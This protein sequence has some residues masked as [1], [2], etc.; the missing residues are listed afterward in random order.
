MTVVAGLLV[1][2][3]VA[4]VWFFLDYIKGQNA[5]H[6]ARVSE[7][8]TRIQHPEIVRPELLDRRVEVAPTEP[9]DE[10]HLI[11]TISGGSTMNGDNADT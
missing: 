11:G 5:E 7:L 4:T 6:E 1:V 3:I 10:M 9:E 8:L 2:A